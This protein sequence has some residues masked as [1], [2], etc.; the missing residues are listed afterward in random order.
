MTIKRPFLLVSILIFLLAA[1]NS[2][3][4]ATP[5][6]EPP[7]TAVPQ[8]TDTLDTIDDELMLADGLV[9]SEMLPG[10]T[11]NNLYEFVEL[12][13]AG[14]TAVDLNGWSLWYRINSDKDEE[15]VA[16]WETET[17]VPPQGHY[18]LLHEGQEFNLMADALF[19][20]SL[21]PRK[22]G[23]VLR[24]A[25][26][27]AVDAFGWGEAPDGFAAG[28]AAAPPDAGASLE[29]LPGGE[30][31][32]GQTTGVNGDDLAVNDSPSP[33]NSGSALTPLPDKMLALT[34][35]M[36][37]VVMP[38]ETFALEVSVTNQTGANVTDVL[39]SVPVADHFEVAALPE[40]VER[41][42]G[43]VQWTI[44]Q[45]EVDGRAT[46]VISLQS[47]YT[48]VDTLMH[49]AFAQADGLLA[50]YAPPRL[51]T[52]AGGAIPI[53]AARE[54]VGSV[55]SVEGIAT[56]YTGGF[57]A[58]STGTKFYLEDE[59]GGIQ[60]YV[61]GGKGRVNIGIGDRV[62]ATGT[63]E[64][65]RDS[66]ELI[67]DVALTDVEVITAGEMD[68]PA[69]EISLTASQSDDAVL[70]R[71]N[72]VSGT[73]VRIDEFSFSYEIDLM[74]EA[75]NVTLV[76]I[77]KD[78]GITAEPLELGKQYQVTGISEFY[79]NARQIKPRLQ[80]DIAEIFPPELMIGLTAANNVLPG[81]IIEYAIAVFNYTDAPLTNVRV[82]AVAP[83]IAEIVALNEGV[84]ADGVIEWLIDELAADGGSA[85]VS[86][87]VWV[88][89]GAMGAITLPPALAAA[90]QW[91]EPVSTAS[92][93]TF[94]GTGVPIWAIQGDG[95]RSP[96]ARDEVMT[97][98][99]VTAV[100]PELFGFWLQGE[101]DGDP[102]TSDGVFVLV[103]EDETMPAA[104][105]DLVQVHGR[106]RELSGQ[107]TLDMS[108]VTLL[109]SEMP[110]PDP[111]PLDPPADPD[112]ALVYLESLEGMLVAVNETA[113]AIAPT[114]RYG[115]YT[116]VLQKWGASTVARTDDAGYLIYV[117]DGSMMAH[118]NQATMAYVVSGGDLVTDLVGPLAFTF[119]NYKIEPMAIPQ[120][121]AGERPLPT[122]PQTAPNQFSVATFNVENLFDLVDPHPS[123]P[124]R[125]TLDE[126]RTR[127]DKVAAA[128]VS[129]AAPTIVGLQEV[130]N[131][132]ILADLIELEALAIYGYMPALIEGDDSRG[133]DVGFIV[134]SDQA[135]IE[136]FASYPAPGELF[137]RPPLLITTTIHL[138]TGDQ[139]VYV[140]NNHFLSLSGGEAATEPIR[141]AQ[142]AWNA[143]LV[144]QIQASDPDGHVIVL[145]DL[146]SFYDT[147]P[148]HT[149]QAAGLRHV[150][151]A[152][153]PDEPL[154]Y[155]YIYQGR[156]QTLDHILVSEG[157]FGRM[158]A[159]TAL[160]IDAD[161]PLAQPEDA[162]A[163][164]VSDHDPLIAV[165]TFE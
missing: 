144:A 152:V 111:I 39:V 143:E 73:A 163:R 129:M 153:G 136:G 53:A 140:L 120:I 23:L 36:P 7:P 81:E 26:G 149:L 130:E 155:T 78:T 105:G 12:Y 52:M 122:L 131:I 133:I 125:P 65:Y 93:V 100:F 80:S 126:Y 32:N 45:I 57:Y 76:Y 38:G 15:L 96:Y 164:R 141:N 128:I 157:L 156:T 43:R 10:I 31:G 75:G 67:P 110:L 161:Y 46:A 35:A 49:S 14:K 135:T 106:V 118:E 22:G 18:L 62:R 9:I 69:T 119:G 150:Y 142:A 89:E 60:V 20:V 17:H 25:D 138:P 151:E 59:T 104:V 77:E 3:P 146:N 148:I 154:P 108:E 82:M 85:A 84:A 27:K 127:L 86:F 19:T 134:R 90:D 29:R 70:G 74:D 147:R 41:V 2:E 99:V 159:V 44:P 87:E 103:G 64:V 28:T 160:K 115:E 50:A 40:G 113:V 124:P 42:N 94:V 61:P 101:E 54:L 16:A 114:T 79:S 116:L 68:W 88:P 21:S 102:A 48:Y 117:D 158:T 37:D 4:E 98:G 165:F 51:I 72:R 107:T 30:Q 47:P 34:V 56:M 33:Q 91:P 5:T 24:D 121:V 58:G 1:C 83:E 109:S 11:G 8:P 139:T 6:P 13:N 55:V 112:E 95:E 71:L 92:Y 137:S 123:S 66:L 63:I 97:E 132:D 145:G 162:T